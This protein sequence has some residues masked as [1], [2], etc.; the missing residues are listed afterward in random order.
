MVSI[1]IPVFNG[2]KYIKHAIESCLNQ[3][4]KNIEIIVIDDGSTDGLDVSYIHAFHTTIKF[5]SK[6]NEGL[7]R[8]RNLG[9][10]LAKGEYIFFLDADDTLPV[11]AIQTLRE[12]IDGNDFAIGRCKRVYYDRHQNIYHEVIWKKNIFYKKH[13]KYNLIIDTIAT[14]KLYRK[15]FLV[16]NNINFLVGLYEDKLFTLKVFE[17]SQKFIYI[18]DVVYHWHIHYNSASITNSLSINNLKERMKVNYQCMEY[19][20]DQLLLKVLCQNIIKHD[21]KVYI[22]KIHIYSL[23]E[24]AE[25]Y[26][27]YKNFL[28]KYDS[29]IDK[30]QYFVDKII[31][32]EIH[33]KE[34]ILEEFLNISKENNTK[35]K[36]VKLK[37]YIRYLLFYAKS[38]FR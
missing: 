16:Q 34:L 2:K 15:I 32:E 27:I 26:T 29:L 14:N 17:N 4:Y 11:G 20:N 33:D 24:R 12:I 36:W 38:S 13:N 28:I 35:N 9:M 10:S 18:K 5:F 8:T 19:I 25:L 6:Q 22:N 1:I 23:E 31:L 3:S 7:G 30:K 37:K 21:F